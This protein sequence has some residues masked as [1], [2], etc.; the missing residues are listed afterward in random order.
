MSKTVV[1]NAATMPE[2]FLRWPQ[3]SGDLRHIPTTQ[4]LEFAPLE[5]IPD[6]LLRIEIR[7]LARQALQVQAFGRASLE[8]L[9]ADLRTVDGR[10]IPDHQQLARNLA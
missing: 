1:E 6:P 9:L 3:F 2:T 8:K 10:P 5:Q 4:V 7:S